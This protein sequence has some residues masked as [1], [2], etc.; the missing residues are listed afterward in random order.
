M[1]LGLS[2]DLRCR[3]VAAVL[4]E[5]M[6][7]RGAAARFGVAPSTAIRWCARMRATGSAAPKP[8]GGDTRS[9]RIE[10]QADF[11]LGLWEDQRD[12]TLVEVQRRLAERGTPVGIGTVHRFF[13][14][15]G[16][17]RKKRPGTRSN[18]TARTS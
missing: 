11:I 4:D 16:L 7:C 5:A 6:S 8:Q 13:Q 17:T 18:R 12:I 2:M 9:H 15:H 3:V 14:R 10:A 1:G